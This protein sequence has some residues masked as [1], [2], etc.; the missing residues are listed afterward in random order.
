MPNFE[1]VTASALRA[2]HLT[3]PAN[4]ST[5]PLFDIA[6][7]VRKNWKA[8]SKKGIYFGAVPYLDAM[9]SLN[10]VDDSFGYD[11][12]RSILIYFLGN[13]TSWRGEVAKAVKTELKR[14]IK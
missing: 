12:G 1:I 7:L 2:N 8:T 10:S 14:R 6:F 9:A 5:M 13:A 11:D 3:I 4:L